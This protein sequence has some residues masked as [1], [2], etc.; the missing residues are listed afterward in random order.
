LFA[1]A[2]T[3]GLLASF[4]D[5]YWQPVPRNQQKTS[6]INKLAIRSAGSIVSVFGQ[7]PSH[8]VLGRGTLESGQGDGDGASS[9]QNRRASEVLLAIFFAA[10]VF[11]IAIISMQYVRSRIF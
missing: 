3:G 11:A 1:F 9:T 8:G 10:G 5:N 7:H 6:T 4:L 2:L